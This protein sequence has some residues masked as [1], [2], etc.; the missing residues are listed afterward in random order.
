MFVSVALAL[1][2]VGAFALGWLQ[3]AA[4][5][6]LG[7]GFWLFAGAATVLLV[8]AALLLLAGAWSKWGAL[9]VA[10]AA[11]LGLGGWACEPT[12]AAL[13]SWGATL[14]RIRFGYPLLLFLLL[15][16]P[17]TFLIA[18]RPLFRFESL[19]PWVA[20]ILRTAGMALLVLALARPVAP[21]PQQ[22]VTALFVVDRSLSIPAQYD[23]NDSTV[24]LRQKRI[25][26]FLNK[27]V[28][29]RNN[30]GHASDRAGLIVFGKQPRLEL[31]A[32][33]APAFNLRK[34]PPV[35]D[36]TKAYTDIG[37]R[38]RRWPSPP[39][40]RTRPSASSSSATAT[41]TAATP[42]SRPSRPAR[43][44]CRSSVLPLR[45]GQPATSRR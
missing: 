1:P 21:Q 45:Q 23:P 35:A 24:D 2:A 7:W 17:L 22:N 44:A 38:H 36:D 42:R 26:D 5:V 18:W 12:T 32:N 31:P 15:L 3:A 27:A 33:D 16:A 34:L 11:L 14:I 40:P 6:F 25:L 28:A 19:R 39:S 8:M 13:A 20:A 37:S 29:E 43:W 30:R 10:G 9:V 4:P 41:R